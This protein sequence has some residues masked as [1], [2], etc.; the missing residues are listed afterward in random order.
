MIFS[1]K[2]MH[3]TEMSTNGVIVIPIIK[4]L[5]YPVG[6]C[7]NN[8]ETDI[9]IIRAKGLTCH[10]QELMRVVYTL[11]HVVAKPCLGMPGFRADRPQENTSHCFGLSDGKFADIL[12]VYLEFMPGLD[13]TLAGWRLWIVM[14]SPTFNMEKGLANFFI[15]EQMRLKEESKTKVLA[16]KPRSV[17]DLAPFNKKENWINDGVSPFLHEQFNTS[18]DD[19]DFNINGNLAHASELFAPGNPAAT[20]IVFNFAHSVDVFEGVVLQDCLLESS[21]MVEAVADTAP[22]ESSDDDDDTVGEAADVEQLLHKRARI[23]NVQKATTR[24]NFPRGAYLIPHLNRTPNEVFLANIAKEPT[25][26]DLISNEATTRDRRQRSLQVNQAILDQDA[27]VTA[28]IG[29]WQTTTKNKTPEEVNTI[30]NSKEAE[31]MFHSACCNYTT[32]P[33]AVVC[34]DWLLEK[35][36]QDPGWCPCSSIDKGMDERLT[37]FGNQVTSEMYKMELVCGINVMHAELFIALLMTLLTSDVDHT[38]MVFHMVLLGGAGTGK[39]FIQSLLQKW[40]C[41]E[42][43]MQFV[44]SQS[45]KANTTGDIKNGFLQVS[46]ELNDLFT[47]K[48]DG[49]GNAQLKELLTKGSIRDI[50]CWIEDGIKKEVVTEVKK[51]VSVLANSNLIKSQFPEPIADRMYTRQAPLQERHGISPVTENWKLRHDPER[52]K[53]IT[54]YGDRWKF[55]QSVASMIF[56][57]SAIRQMN[58]VDLNL[59]VAT[60]SGLFTNLEDDFGVKIRFR[61][62]ERIVLLAKM[63][64]VYDA[65][66]MVWFSGKVLPPKTPF[67]LKDITLLIPYLCGRREHLYFAMSL[68]DDVIVDPSLTVILKA[69]QT[70]VSNEKI[71]EAKFG[72]PLTNSNKPNYNYYAIPIQGFSASDS[73]AVIYTIARTLI[74]TIKSTST[75]DYPESYVANVVRQMMAQKKNVHPYTGVNT[76]NTDVIMKLDVFAIKR[77]PTG[78]S[79]EVLRHFLEDIVNNKKDIIAEAIISTIDQQFPH[80]LLVLGRTYRYGYSVGAGREPICLPFVFQTLDVSK[81]QPRNIMLEKRSYTRFGESFFFDEGSVVGEQR[82]FEVNSCLE[83]DYLKAWC[84]L[85]GIPVPHHAKIK[86]V[87]MGQYPQTLVE[88][89]IEEFSTSIKSMIKDTV[90]ESEEKEETELYNS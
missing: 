87:F 78:F 77:K 82:M 15:L 88:G 44:S 32:N 9:N 28:A 37:D 51:K 10:P 38:D 80:D 52:I 62:K 58:S 74:D 22:A 59:V 46:D 67:K 81:R 6:T 20:R 57:K 17:V 39:S 16:K 40:L 14:A 2:V 21:Y 48:G 73:Q 84:K 7:L 41:I 33:G 45:K 23:I 75:H 55:R 83:Q 69:Y 71:A 64:V 86:R 27:V 31:D 4:S 5:L 49:S 61:D 24:V 13:N 12:S 90:L 79:F 18:S 34:C 11:L 66:N 85:N 54:Q 47:D 60:A 72:I 1:K 42:K 19:Y 43:L 8:F 89:Y 56:V 36:R 50:I 3:S 70:I 53:K 76:K 26:E 25:P 35:I 30:R 63:L 29:W 65:I 68:M